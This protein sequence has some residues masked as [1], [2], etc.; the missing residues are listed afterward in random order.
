MNVPQRNNRLRAEGEADVGGANSKVSA[1]E[2]SAGAWLEQLGQDFRFALRSMMKARAFTAVA[3][4]TLAVG[5]G[6]NTAM[7]SVIYGVLL[8][9]YPY[10]K[11]NEIWAPEVADAKTGRGGGFRVS[12]YLEIAKLPA[13]ATAMA[14]GFSSV[15]L[16]GDEHREIINAPC[17]TSSA[18]AFLGVTPVL[19]RG[20]APADFKANG[21]PEPVCVLSFQLWQRLFNGD[22]SAVGRSI[23]LNDQPH[24]VIGVMPPRFGWYGNDGLWLPLA[25]TDLQRNVRPIV[26]LQ[27]GVS[28]EV[29]GQQLYAL[30]QEVAK[31]TPARVPKDG[32]TAKF[33][34]YLDVTVSSGEMRSSLHLL[35]YAVGFLLLIACTNVANLQLARGASRAR[36]LAVRLA[37]G[38]G[39]GRLVRQLLTESVVL[40]LAGGALGVLF[41][42]WLTQGIVALMPD[43]Y[44][45][46]EARV[47]L[48]VWVLLFSAGV[49]IL[50]GVLFGL[51]PAWQCTRADVNHALKEGA[52]AAS[53]GVAA[54]RTRNVLVIVE[55]ALS[56]VL[57]VGAS[58]TI[59]GF[60]DLQRIDRGFRSERLIVFRMPLSPTRYATIEQRNA[61]ARQFLERV[62][63]VPGVAGA[64]VGMIPGFEGGSGAAIAGQEKILDGIR[65]N[66]VDFDYVS[67]LGVTLR[68][69]RNLTEQEVARG[70]R[71]ALINESAAKLWGDGVSPLGR[72]IAVDSL[73][74]GGANNLPAAGAV[75]EVT[76]I[77]IVAD[78][79]SQDKRRPA[80]PSVMVPYTLRAPLDRMFLVRTHGDPASIVNVV[81]SGLRAMDSQQAMIAP[82]VIDDLLD[83]QVAQPRFNMALFSAFAGTALVLAMAGIYSVLSYS[84]AQ[85]TR[86]IGVRIA[87]GAGSAD[88]SR[89]ILSAGARLLLIGTATGVA[90]SLGLA[91]IMRSQVFNIPLLDPLSFAAA[92]LLL[93]TAAGFACWWPARRAA[94][95]DPMVALRSD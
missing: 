76:V 26:R 28:K 61:F 8:D 67:T 79:R 84:V 63:A 62:R 90:I 35:L 22:R 64:T 30:V 21:E 37:V 50:T 13:V 31:Q 86:E 94:R 2:R 46:N 56:I 1:R 43:F 11:S 36:E 7:F 65:I 72:T 20:I 55:V 38:A 68:G 9:P 80:P 92:V 83:Q 95:I 39:R 48:N 33:H 17:L 10:A 73:V 18:F 93:G 41:A 91:Q 57:L 24:V 27:P 19:G 77:G 25:T 74:G 29:A 70:D 34:N 5:I 87:L 71:V 66:F 3:V 52:Q 44:V 49:S 45:P 4:L 58:L 85:R 14:T 15:T 47:T 59:R 81:R 12:D 53:G 75:K 89:L 32:F 82:R 51:V 88:I 42:F 6:V 54:N 40:S 60:V 16:S 69:G 23:V 78:V